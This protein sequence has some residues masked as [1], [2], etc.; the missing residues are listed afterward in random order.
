LECGYRG[1]YSNS[2]VYCLLYSSD[3]GIMIDRV[4]VNGYSTLAGGI[5]DAAGDFSGL[6]FPIFGYGYFDWQFG[7]PLGPQGKDSSWF[8][9]LYPAEGGSCEYRIRF[10]E[11]IASDEMAKSAN[12]AATGLRKQFNSRLFEGWQNSHR[13]PQRPIGFFAFVGDWGPEPRGGTGYIKISG[14]HYFDTLRRM[15]AILDENG[16]SNAQIYFWVMLYDQAE[17]NTAPYAGWGY[18]PLD[19]QDLKNFYKQLRTIHDIKLG[20]YVNFWVSS[21]KSPVYKAHPDWFSNQYIGVDSGGAGYAGKLPAWGDYLAGQ[22]PQLLKAYGLDF[23]FFDGANWAPRWLGTHE[24]CKDFFIKISKVMHDNGAE[25]LANSDVP[26]VDIGMYE[27]DAG[28]DKNLDMAVASNFRNYT[29]HNYIFSPFYAWKTWEPNTIETSGK[30]IVKYFADKPN[31]IVRWP[32]HFRGELND[33]ILKDYFTP[34]VQ[35]RAVAM[36]KSIQTGK[37]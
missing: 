9:N 31:F 36:N 17:G 1:A 22:M 34:F 4:S 8:D 15:R 3:G 12:I 21:V 6:T 27:Y 10:F 11:R 2:M 26:F 33:H 18:F 7:H 23:V 29:Y 32:V 20:V 5:R 19:A 35:R 30:S 37:K 13:E 25:F 14:E 24:Q 16:L 28:V